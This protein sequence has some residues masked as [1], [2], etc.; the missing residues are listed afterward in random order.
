MKILNE[1]RKTAVAV[2]AGLAQAGVAL[3]DGHISGAEGV[4]I[5]LA[6]LAALG[7]YAV[8]NTPKES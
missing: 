7:V 5:A 1:A 6:F 3:E 2:A 4:A 8:A